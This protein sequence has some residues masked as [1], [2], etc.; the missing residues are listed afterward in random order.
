MQ[1]INKNHVKILVWERGSGRTL[2]CGTGACAVVV[3]GILT[4]RLSSS[5]KVTLEGGDLFIEWQMDEQILSNFIE[6]ATVGSLSLIEARCLRP[7][8]KTGPAIEVYRGF[9]T[10]ENL[11]TFACVDRAIPGPLIS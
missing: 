8:I 5:C 11:S 3:A 9:F 1:V 2:A 10:A 4:G 6:E 7:V